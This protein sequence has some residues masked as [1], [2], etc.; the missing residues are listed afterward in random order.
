M[1]ANA[2]CFLS[3]ASARLAAFNGNA[4]A[5]RSPTA[6]LNNS[7]LVDPRPPQTSAHEA[8]YILLPGVML[9]YSLMN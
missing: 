4:A 6:A 8:H 7:A 2:L 5:I 3:Y 9:P 1:S